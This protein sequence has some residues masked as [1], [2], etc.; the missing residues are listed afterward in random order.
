MSTTSNKLFFGTPVDLAPLP[1]RPLVSLLVANY[2]Y[3]GYIGA[4]LDSALG[5][6]YDNLEICVC[7]DGSQDDSV[8]VIEGYARRDA[9]IRLTSKANGGAASALN[10]AYAM[11]R[12]EIVCL[13]DADDI[14]EPHKVET[15]VSAFREQGCGL[16]V[17]PLLVIDEQGAAIQR[18]PAFGHLER[19]WIADKVV[20]RGGRWSYMEASAVCLRR[21]VAELAFPIPENLFRTWADAYL[22]CLG[23]LLAPIGSVDEALARYRIHT[24]NVSGFNTFT[25]DHGAKAMNGFDRL[26]EGV[27]RGLQRAFVDPPVLEATDNLTYIEARLQKELLEGGI[28]LRQSA[29]TFVEYARRV[30]GDD[31]YGGARKALSIFFLGSAL[32]LPRGVRS[33]WLSAGLT[34]SRTKE[35]LR[36]VAGPMLRA[37]R[38]P[39]R[40]RHA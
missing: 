36:R 11:S 23:A 31:I 22:C 12:G 28:P 16:L 9:R 13:L 14:F 29:A 37:L 1:E 20:A 6:T 21:E 10:V 19:G 33:R 39:L 2:N 24:A 8:A 38:R 25:P 18:K 27:N 40:R 35:A 15:V 32:L 4:A 3:A 7:D 34:H 30:L 17:H 26:T 5:Q